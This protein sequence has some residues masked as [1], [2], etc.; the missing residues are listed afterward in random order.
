VDMVPDSRVQIG[1]RGM[2][3]LYKHMRLI[4]LVAVA[5]NLFVPNLYLL[6]GGVAIYV[7]SYAL[8]IHKIEAIIEASI[9]EKEKED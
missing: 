3:N 1:D 2:F 6:L 4:A 8:S 7:W 5:I 9:Q